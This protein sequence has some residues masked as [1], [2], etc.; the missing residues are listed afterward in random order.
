MSVSS[1]WSKVL[2]VDGQRMKKLT[3]AANHALLGSDAA[4]RH[5]RNPVAAADFIRVEDWAVRLQV[6]K[7][8]VFRMIDEGIIPP[9]DFA[10]GKTKRWHRST[11]ENWVSERVGG[12]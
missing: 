2:P 7:R 9:Y 10:M 3:N 8:T 1:R 5:Q 11:Y 6:S 4:S 12:H